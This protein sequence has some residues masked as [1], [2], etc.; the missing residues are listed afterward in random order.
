MV[1]FDKLY[2][3]LISTSGFGSRIINE[4]LVYFLWFSRNRGY[5][6]YVVVTPFI[7]SGI[8]SVM[9]ALSLG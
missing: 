1:D 4:Y 9:H 7:A 2:N 8:V 3:I 5:V 6:G